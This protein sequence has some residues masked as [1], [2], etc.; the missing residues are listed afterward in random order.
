MPRPSSLPVLVL[1]A[2]SGCTEL[3][4]CGTSEPAPAQ[5]LAAAPDAGTR[6]STPSVAPPPPEA[7]YAKKWLVIVHSSSTPGEG[8][9]VLEALKGTGLPAEPLRLSTNA[10][11]DLRPCLEVVVAKVFE[12]RA[13]AEGFRGQLSQAG[14]VAYEKNAGPLDPERE[15]KDATCRA[16]AEAEAARA[17]ALNRRTVPRFV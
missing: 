5:G 3:R 13:E 4:G 1:L 12:A 14:V 17:Q 10:F 6:A 2:L 9:G 8:S 15:R 16:E 7:R 11:K